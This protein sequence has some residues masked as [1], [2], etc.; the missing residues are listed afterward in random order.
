MQF[1]ALL[2]STERF[3]VSPGVYLMKDSR[4]G[5]LYVGK[6]VNLRSRVR[7]YFS[8]DHA[9]RPHIIPMLKRLHHVEWIATTSNAEALILEANL[10]RTHAPP[11]NIELKDDKHFPYLKITLQEAFP[12]M[13]VARRVERDG[14]KY[15]GPYTDAGAMRR[16]MAFARKAFRLRDCTRRLPLSRPVRPCI[17]YSMGQ[18]SGAC[19]GLTDEETYRANVEHLVQ[20]LRGR[21]TELLDE[22][23]HRMQQASET[24]Q[25]ER[26][27]QF[28][29]QVRLVRDA[30]RQQR[31]D[32]AEAQGDYDV[33]GVHE[34]ERD[35]CLAVM[36]FRE[37]VL[38]GSR[39]FLVGRPSWE[40]S[41]GQ[42]DETVLRYYFD[43]TYDPP[44]EI[45]A[46][47]DLL[48][49]LSTLQDWFADQRSTTVHV[50]VP[51]RGPKRELVALAQRNARLYLVQKAPHRDE[52]SVRDLREVLGLPVLPRVIEAFDISNLGASFAV[53]GMVQFVDGAPRRAGYRRFRIRSVEGQDDFAM[54]IEA[55]TRR[56]ARLTAENKPFPD[57]LL[58]DGGKGQLSAVRQ[59]LGQFEHP[60]AAVSLAKGEEVLHS[61][62][63]QSEV[64]LPDTH[65]AR[66]LVERIRD[67]VHR[68]ALSY[69]RLLRGGQFKRSALEEI[70]G[71][72]PATA[73]RLLRQFG[74]I[75]RLRK[76]GVEEIAAV[77]GVTAAAA[78]AVHATLARTEP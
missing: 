23:E 69:H 77:R 55:V 27:A 46:P 43:T 75:R 51:Q 50:H 48:S 29:D 8:D 78:R 16:V 28:R 42:F 21:R 22:L 20:F 58:I 14:A 32:L 76:A 12:R 31:V 36:H 17:N 52:D 3:P 33:F 61:P 9:D 57:L 68:Y 47:P 63:V 73:Q 60:P 54:L 38:M 40:L 19:A 37:G 44:A 13:V 25:Y 18:C 74:S 15:F 72:G 35:V 53:A 11:Y 62:F 66:R 49:D 67:E 65:P 70:P 34:G 41:A 59:A 26:A 39:H 45:L 1:S 2:E 5:V 4:D 7:S 10:V 30:S 6:A 56:L 24:L 71:V 64:R